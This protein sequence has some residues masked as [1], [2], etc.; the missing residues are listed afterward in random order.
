M[1]AF[2]SMRSRPQLELNVKFVFLTGPSEEEV[3]V[4]QPPEFEVGGTKDVYRM[5]KSLCGLK[6]A[7]G[8]IATKG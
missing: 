8:P 6:Q 1:I 7:Q 3:Y 4:V 2:T 5:K